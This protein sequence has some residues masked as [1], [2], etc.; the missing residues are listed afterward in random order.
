M[1]LIQPSKPTQNAYIES[2]NGKFRDEYLNSHWFTSLSHARAVIAAWR[3]GYNEERPHSAL[4]YLSRAQFA[5]KHRATAD[6]SCRI[7][8]TDLNGLC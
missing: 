3:L 5:A 8:G 7:S 6:A 2:F 4:N 1:K